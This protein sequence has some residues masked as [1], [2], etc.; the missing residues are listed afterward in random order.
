VGTHLEKQKE[1]KK[2]IA[3]SLNSYRLLVGVPIG[4]N[5]LENRL[6]ISIKIHTNLL[7]SN[8]NPNTKWY[9]FV[10]K[11]LETEKSSKE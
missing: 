11:N 1:E 10:T 3:P 6:V 8:S 7:P 9:L 5:T 4:R 2:C